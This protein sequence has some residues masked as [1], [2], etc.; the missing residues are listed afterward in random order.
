MVSLG[1]GGSWHELPAGLGRG[2]LSVVHVDELGGTQVLLNFF[3]YFI[4]MC[5]T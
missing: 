3:R 4:S 2:I 1:S 5:T